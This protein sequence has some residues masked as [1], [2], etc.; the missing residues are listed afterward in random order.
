MGQQM[1]EVLVALLVGGLGRT[2]V[3]SVRSSTYNRHEAND[4][5]V[6]ANPI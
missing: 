5:A 3:S 4:E 2:S 6:V 1:V